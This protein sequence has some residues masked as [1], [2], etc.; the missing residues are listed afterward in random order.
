M[1]QKFRQ[2]RFIWHSFRDKCVF[3]FYA[4]IQDGC[5]KLRENNFCERSSVDSADTLRVKKFFEIALPSTI[6]FLCF[7]QKFKI[8]AKNGGKMIFGKNRQYTLQTLWVKHFVKIALSH[9]IS[10]INAFFRFI[11]KFKMAGK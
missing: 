2:N 11:Q 5:Q 1:G 7:T 3:A 6:S 8:T 9:T 10:D 4:E